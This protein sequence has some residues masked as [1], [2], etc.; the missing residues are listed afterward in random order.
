VQEEI[1]GLPYK[2][3]R[4]PGDKPVIVIHHQ[5]EVKKFYPEEIQ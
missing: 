2:V 4:G 5:K 3:E 1:R